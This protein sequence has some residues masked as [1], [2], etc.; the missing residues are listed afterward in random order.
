MSGHTFGEDKAEAEIEKPLLC[1]FRGMT[2]PVTVTAGETVDLKFGDEFVSIEFPAK[3]DSREG[4]GPW[5]WKIQYVY[6]G[7]RGEK[8]LVPAFI[9]AMDRESAIRILRGMVDRP[10]KIHRI[11]KQV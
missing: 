5:L 4:T 9:R 2:L 10:I 8:T 11:T 6:S 3:V 7:E 1:H